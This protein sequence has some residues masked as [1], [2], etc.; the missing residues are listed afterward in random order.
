ML[1]HTI[2]G[3]I[4][5]RA[6]R[7]VLEAGEDDAG[8]DQS[9]FRAHFTN[10]FKTALEFLQFPDDGGNPACNSAAT[11]ATDLV[12]TEPVDR[13]SACLQHANAHNMVLLEVISPAGPVPDALAALHG[14]VHGDR[15]V[16][17]RTEPGF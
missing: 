12:V 17:K 9:S 13:L 4:F 5:A 6:S 11:L 7:N 8:E 1:A 15:R 3:Q 2:L 14:L 16:L 10:K